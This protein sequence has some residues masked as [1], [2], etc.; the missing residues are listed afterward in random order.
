MRTRDFLKRVAKAPMYL[1]LLFLIACGSDSEE[2]QGD[3]GVNNTNNNGPL[4][5]TVYRTDLSG[6]SGTR[7][8]R[9][10]NN[11][12]CTA[13]QSGNTIFTG[14][15]LSQVA[16][17]NTTTLAGQVPL[18]PGSGGN[19]NNSMVYYAKS[20]VG[21][22]MFLTRTG[23]GFDVTFSMCETLIETYDYYGTQTLRAFS[24]R[25]R[26]EQVYTGYYGIQIKTPV[27]PNIEEGAIV[28]STPTVYTNISYHDNY[29]N[30]NG[31]NGQTVGYPVNF[32]SEVYY[33]S[34][35]CFQ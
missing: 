30:Y 2:Q 29:G 35:H 21:D 20:A 24:D 18:Q 7:I 16:V 25:N 3:D 27:C 19:D 1:A 22:L 8:K 12:P 9:L 34:P 26:I 11:T 4:N 6:S 31:S 33:A 10:R 23:N 14:Q 32:Y 28:T 13:G 15:R 17:F 5:G